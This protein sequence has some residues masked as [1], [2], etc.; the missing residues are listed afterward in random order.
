MKNIMSY[1]QPLVNKRTQKYKAFFVVAGIVIVGFFSCISWLFCSESAPSVWKLSGS[2]E[3]LY[4]LEWLPKLRPGVLYGMFSSYDRSGGNDDGFRGTYS[5]LR[6]EDGN[7]VIAEMKGAGCIT[8]IWFTH[9]ELRK[10]GLLALQGEHIKIY[11]NGNPEPVVDIPLER[12]FSGELERFPKPLVGEGLGGFYC[13]VPIPYSDGCKVVVEGD[14][15]RFYQLTYNLFPDARGIEQFSMDTDI[16]TKKY[17][18]KAVRFWSN[19]GDEKLL[20]LSDPIEISETLDLEE[21]ETLHISLPDGPHQVRAI[22]L[23]GDAENLRNTLSAVL[24]INWEGESVPAVDIPASYIFGQAFY[25]DLFQSLLAGAKPGQYYAFFPMPYQQSADLKVTASIPFSC[26]IRIIVEKLT[27]RDM[28]LAYFHVFYRQE[29]PTIN[30]KY[31][32]LVQTNGSGH[33]IG[34]YL[35]TEMERPQP[36]PEWL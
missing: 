3:A 18:S 28:P 33:Y 16:K 7:S 2:V 13:Y 35:V 32:K 5:K 6:L 36:L 12:M 25:P 17:L 21:N 10:D 31:Y 15:V 20:E 30:G 19:P 24:Q 1:L 26:R 23:E 8:R 9:S 29:V 14:N 11:L 27:S 34:T 4:R 22:L